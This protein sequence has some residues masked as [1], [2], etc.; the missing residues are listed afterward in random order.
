MMRIP[1]D[2]RDEARQAIE[3]TLAEHDPRFIAILVHVLEDAVQF[4][5]RAARDT[6][7]AE[8]VGIYRELYDAD[9]SNGSGS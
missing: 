1:E 8:A 5:D 3:N 2:E 6:L 9:T 4:V 7:I